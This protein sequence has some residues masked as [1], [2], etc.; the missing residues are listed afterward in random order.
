MIRLVEQGYTDGIA[1]VEEVYK[2]LR[3][4]GYAPGEI[5]TLCQEF[6]GRPNS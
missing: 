5:L 1:Y 3:G 2:I 4:K 6:F